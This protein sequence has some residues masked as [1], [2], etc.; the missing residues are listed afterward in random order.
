MECVSIHILYS[1]FYGM[2]I[3]LIKKEIKLVEL[4]KEKQLI[5][6]TAESCTAGLVSAAI[7]NVSGASTVFKEGYITYCDESKRRL[8]GVSQDT[9][10]KYKAVS[11]QTAMEMAK[12]AADKARAD[13]GISVTGVAGPD[14]EDGKP[15]G[16]VYTGIYYYNDGVIVNKAYEHNLKGDRQQIR[17][18]AVE[19]AIDMVIDVIDDSNMDFE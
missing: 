12:G 19:C 5:I 18:Q 10:N 11:A 17:N 8:L 6:T 14:T 2:E 15:V 4:L 3:I 13:I 16:L 7:V 9:L 1:I